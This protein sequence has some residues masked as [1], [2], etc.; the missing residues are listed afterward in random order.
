M[1]KMFI[2]KWI[3][4]IDCQEWKILMIGPQFSPTLFHQELIYANLEPLNKM[5]SSV[6]PWQTQPCWWSWSE[7][8]SG[9]GLLLSTMN[10]FLPINV[11]LVPRK[12][13]TSCCKSWKWL[14]TKYLASFSRKFFVKLWVCPIFLLQVLITVLTL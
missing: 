4:K 8:R 13:L 10:L 14:I 12:C 2:K 5:H 9:R 11:N 3:N 7:W 1:L 6:R